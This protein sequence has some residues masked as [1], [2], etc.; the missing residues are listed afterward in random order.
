VDA[1]A[2]LFNLIRRDYHVVSICNL[3]DYGERIVGPEM[4]ADVEFHRGE[5][6]F[7]ELVG[8]YANA[9]LAFTCAG[10]APVLAQAVSTRCVVVYGGHEGFRTTNSVGAHLAPTLAIEPI[11]VCECHGGHYRHVDNRLVKPARDH[12]CDKTID[13]VDAMSRLLE[14]VKQR[15][16]VL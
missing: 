11:R 14:F 1:Y 4:P 9:E 7:E 10:F 3:G 2:S 8:M 12:E 13:L 6:F 5:L 15:E 16:L